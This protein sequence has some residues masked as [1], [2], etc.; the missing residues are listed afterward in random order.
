MVLD[1]VGVG[2]HVGQSQHR[3]PSA[4]EDLGALQLSARW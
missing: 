1:R 4:Q 2:T 3:V